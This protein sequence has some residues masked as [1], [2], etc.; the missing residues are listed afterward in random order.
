[1]TG[2]TTL[3]ERFVEW[4]TRLQAVPD[5][6]RQVAKWHVLDALG[7]GLAAARLGVVDFAVTEAM[8]YRAPAES[9]VLGYRTRHPAPM[10]ALANGALIHGLDFD[11]THA[12]AILHGSAAVLPAVLAVSETVDADLDTAVDAF[13]VGLE[14]AIRVAAAASRKFHVRG[15]H[16]TSVVGVFGATLAAGRLLGIDAPATVNALGVAGSQA[17][18][19]LEFLYTGSLTKPLHPG[20]A[21]LAAVMAARMAAR[22]ATGPATILEGGW[23]L[24][25]AYADTT[26]EGHAVTAGLGREW[27]TT[28]MTIKPYPVCQYSHATL[29]TVG[30]LPG[31]LALDRIARID[32]GLPQDSLAVVAEPREARLSPRSTHEAKF[33]VQWNVA[34]LLIDGHLSVDHFHDDQLDREDIRRLAAKVFVH[35]RAFDGPLAEAPGD[36]Q[37]TLEGGDT[38]VRTMTTSSATPGRPVDETALMDKFVSNLAGGIPEADRIAKL[39][40][41]DGGL[42]VRELMSMTARR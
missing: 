40:I 42:P 4:S 1:M 28:R 3:S 11:D 19:S 41:E 21:G 15:F 31:D 22:G 6:V 35:R 34:A 2:P 27:E 9:G 18:G 23:G 10:A 16:A 33:S 26:V 38:V 24:Y 29:D 20:W 30:L 5:E 17:S 32:I 25:R 14:M 39:V 12:A 8:S 7:T 13:V 37:V 36:V